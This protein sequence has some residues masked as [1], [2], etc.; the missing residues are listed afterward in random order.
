MRDL[1]GSVSKL[2]RQF[3]TFA[4]E[5]RLA[6]RYIRTDAASSLTKS[7][8][9]LEKLLLSVYT[10]VM[11]QEPRKPM[12]GDMLNDNQFTR[13]I[14]RRIL[15]RM[16]SVRD[17]GNL[18]P[19]GEAVE[20][21]DAAR[22]LEDLCEILEWHLRRS[23]GA[24][25]DVPAE[26]P[27]GRA[28][29]R[30]APAKG[31]EG[32]ADDRSPEELLRELL[33]VGRV[34][35]APP[36]LERAIQ[37]G[38]AAVGQKLLELEPAVAKGLKL[39]DVLDVVSEAIEHG[40]GIYNHSADGRVGCG[41]IYHRAAAGLTAL[42]P[43]APVAAGATP[44]GIHLAIDV[45][46]RI[47][48]AEPT[49]TPENGDDVAWELRFAF[50]S[51]PLVP[52]FDSV[53]GA[54]KALATATRADAPFDLCQL[55]RLVIERMPGLPH[56]HTTAYLLQHT[57]RALLREPVAERLLG[58]GAQPLRQV[59][60]KYPRITR[61]STQHLVR[62]LAQCFV[63]TCQNIETGLNEPPPDPPTEPKSSRRWWPFG[64]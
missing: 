11:G 42:V 62:G 32:D 29:K 38:L 56:L 17:M 14:E 16:H 35:K 57:A 51:L 3:P 12:L 15:S 36:D 7:R 25:A 40:A 13:T 61:Q 19:H 22:V 58:R 64:S 24:P 50:D 18:G 5:L 21:N 31:D 60:D 44:Q 20:P 53:T 8:I 1:E 46:A 37:N 49:V 23:T 39:N 28:E 48:R 33:R 45:L 47:V 59:L 63:Q 27:S 41:R 4:Q 26:P 30:E 43:P 6:L 10:A 2:E 34:A 52:L 9:V 54:A 55:L